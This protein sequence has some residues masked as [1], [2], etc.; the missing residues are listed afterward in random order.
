MFNENKQESRARGEK[1]LF[2]VIL[3]TLMRVLIWNNKNVLCSL[4]P[5]PRRIVNALQL[6]DYLNKKVRKL[7]AGITRKVRCGLPLMSTAMFQH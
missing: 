7:P 5:F 1:F 4:V 3:G 6:Q 2:L